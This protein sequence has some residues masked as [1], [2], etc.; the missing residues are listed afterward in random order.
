MNNVLDIV[1]ILD[2]SEQGRT[3]PFLCRC[4]DDQLY[5]VKGHAAGKRSLLCEWMAGHLAHAID[6]PVPQFRIVQASKALLDLHPEGRDLG[7]APAFGSLKVEHAQELTTSH[8][9]DISPRLQ[10]DILVFDWWVRN[11][12]RFLTDRGGNPNLLWD[13]SGSRLV[14]IDHNLAFDREYDSVKFIQSHVFHSQIPFVFHDLA[15]K[16]A[17]SRRL[18]EALAVWPDACNNAPAEWWFADDEQTVPTDFDESTALVSLNRCI[19]EEFWRLT[20]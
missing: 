1:E 14:V 7:A 8:L 19:T 4:D 12:D 16:G 13:A 5:F 17:Y 9:R 6:L 18:R 10:R 20:L 15:E 11:G 2:R 3:H